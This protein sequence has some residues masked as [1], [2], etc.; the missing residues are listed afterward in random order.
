MLDSGHQCYKICIFIS[1]VHQLCLHDI[2]L[3]QLCLHDVNNYK[4][5]RIFESSLQSVYSVTVRH[6]NS[7]IMLCVL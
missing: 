4:Y 2:V 3:F 1:H 5:I 6:R 7:N